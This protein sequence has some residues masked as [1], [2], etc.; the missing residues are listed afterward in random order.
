MD[1]DSNRPLFTVNSMP[2]SSR[3]YQL[4]LCPVDALDLTLGAVFV[5]Q[6]AG[7]VGQFSGAQL[8]GRHGD[9]G[10]FNAASR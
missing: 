9:V 2:E 7:Q 3:R 8:K 10:A 5:D 6:I 1:S 4:K